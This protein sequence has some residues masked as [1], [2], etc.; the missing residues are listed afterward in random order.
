VTLVTVGA[1]RLSETGSSGQLG[2]SLD[3]Q[4][5]RPKN[6]H[7]SAASFPLR[8]ITPQR[9]FEREV[10]YLRLRDRTGFFGIM[11]GHTALLTLLDTALGYYRT[12]DGAEIFL[13]V[14]GG[15][16]SVEN[17]RATISSPEL[18]EGADAADLAR[19]I[20]QTRARRQES[21]R[22]FSKMIDGLEREFVKKTLTFLKGKPE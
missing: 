20:E 8:V 11:R 9:F 12:P 15:L 2:R 6:H 1:T 3:K 17:G 14:D 22:I 4:G 21:E 10:S 19:R 13:A 18:F 5:A 16:F 7:M